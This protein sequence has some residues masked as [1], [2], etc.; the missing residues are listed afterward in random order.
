MQVPIPRAKQ[1]EHASPQTRRSVSVVSAARRVLVPPA[2]LVT[3]RWW[4]GSRKSVIWRSRWLQL[5]LD[6]R[7]QR[8]LLNYLFSFRPRN[9]LFVSMVCS[10]RPSDTSINS[11]H[12]PSVPMQIHSVQTNRNKHVRIWTRESFMFIASKYTDV[13]EQSL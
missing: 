7:N 8:W 1:G 13:K 10:L 4:S 5:H 3:F 6:W 9:C 12:K 11:W 2:R